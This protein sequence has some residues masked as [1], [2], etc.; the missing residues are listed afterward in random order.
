MPVSKEQLSSIIAGKAAA[1]CRPEFDNTRAVSRGQINEGFGGPDVSD[2]DGDAER[3]DAMFSDSAHE[4]YG[5]APQARDIQYSQAGAARSQMPDAIKRS[6]MENKIDVSGLGNS[7]VLD[8]LGIKGKPTTA[9]TQRKKQVV[10]EQVQ[11]SAP[12]VGGGVDYSIIK[13]IVSECIK[14]YFSQQPLNESTIKTIA[15]KGGTISLV[16]NGGNIYRAKLEKV[17]NT[18]DKK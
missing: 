4:D 10:N 9:P 3:W 2:Y 5:S 11:Y 7:S 15:L 13:A 16:D 18:K 14:E 8:S 12:Q 17:G 6:M 1:L